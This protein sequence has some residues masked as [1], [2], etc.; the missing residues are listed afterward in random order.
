MTAKVAIY[1]G[2][3]VADCMA[4]PVKDNDLFIF[5]E[6]YDLYQKKHSPADIDQHSSKLALKIQVGIS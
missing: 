1:V 6:V 2:G 4:G 3:E 5:E